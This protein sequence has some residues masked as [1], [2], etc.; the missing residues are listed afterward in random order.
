MAVSAFAADSMKAHG[1]SEW[2]LCSVQCVVTGDTD[3]LL[4][5]VAAMHQ[6]QSAAANKHTSNLTRCIVI[7]S[8]KQ[9]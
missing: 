7:N 2:C 3:F 1:N 6:L 5:T 4:Y 9:L 8:Q